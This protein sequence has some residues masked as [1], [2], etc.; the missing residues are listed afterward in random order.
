MSQRDRS[1]S[2][3]RV[4]APP[5][6]KNLERATEKGFEALAAQAADQMVWLGAEQVADTWRVPVLDETLH[7]DLATKQVLTSAGQAVGP[8]WRILVLHYL[9]IASRP[10][11]LVPETTFGDLAEAR[12]YAGIY[13]GRVVAR[14]CATAGRNAE[15]LGSAANAL[16]GRAV[17]TDS[18]DLA[19]E[20]QIFPRVTVRLVWHAPDEEFPPSATMLLPPNIESYFCSEDIVVL[21][22]SLVSRLCGKA[23]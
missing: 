17:P 2:A 23:F 20:F 11:T 19:F 22:E 3:G 9:A 7:I 4:G 10:E 21:S 12:T 8:A 13:Q 16:G 5:P 14:L 1:A 18:C 15:M 6:Q